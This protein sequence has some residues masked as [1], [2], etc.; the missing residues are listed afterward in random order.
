MILFDTNISGYYGK[1]KIYSP[2]RFGD[3][4]VSKRVV[5]FSFWAYN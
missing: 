1:E 5:F 4:S 2:E 3:L